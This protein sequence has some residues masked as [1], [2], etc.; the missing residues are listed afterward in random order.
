MSEHDGNGEWKP[1][2]MDYYHRFAAGF[3]AS[4]S[5]WFNMQGA[6]T[7]EDNGVLKEKYFRIVETKDDEGNITMNIILDGKEAK[8]TLKD[9]DGWI[10]RE[11]GSK[12][13]IPVIHVRF[14]R[15]NPF[16]STVATLFTELSKDYE[17]SDVPL[18][19]GQL[20]DVD[21][22]RLAPLLRA[23][24]LG[25]VERVLMWTEQPPEA[26]AENVGGWYQVDF[27]SKR[28]SLEMLGKLVVGDWVVRQVVIQGRMSL[29][30][31]GSRLSSRLP[32]TMG[33]GLHLNS[34]EM[35][36]GLLSD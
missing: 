31:P 20:G 23:L 19:V 22:V 6:I 21:A 2:E 9:D 32:Q 34:H 12:K 8:V 16:S 7:Y 1:G 25:K 36:N 28:L 15:K 27:D 13:G 29:Y 17:A 14:L 3:I 10:I 5:R 4:K 30:N 35:I 26:R 18:I 11:D 24:L 33:I